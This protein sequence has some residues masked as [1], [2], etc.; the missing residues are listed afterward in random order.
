MPHRGKI[1]IITDVRSSV[2]EGTIHM[3]QSANESVR[4]QLIDRYCGRLSTWETSW[5]SALKEEQ[6]VLEA[7]EAHPGHRL[8]PAAGLSAFVSVTSN[9]SDKSPEDSV[10]KTSDSTSN[11]NSRGISAIN[12]VLERY[13]L[14]RKRRSH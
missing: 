6:V 1:N 12:K 7:H 3:I 5:F 13:N 9:A 10:D 2:T 4:K 14:V 8:S 11:K